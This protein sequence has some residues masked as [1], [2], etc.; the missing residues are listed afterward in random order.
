MSLLKPL[1]FFSLL[2]LNA[3][4]FAGVSHDLPYPDGQPEADEIARQVYFVNHFYAVKN[5]SFERKG[6]NHI[7]VLVKRPQGGRAST[8]SFRR[9]LNNAYKEG[10][11]KARDMVLFHSGSLMGSGILVTDYFDDGKPQSYSV[12]LPETRKLNVFSEPAHDTAWSDSDFTYGDV[13]LRKPEHENHELLGT[14]TLDD[15]L[16]AM[17]LSEREASKTYLNQLPGP[18]CEHKGKAVY[19]L[20]STTKFENWWYDHRISLVDTRTFADYRTDYY[21][22]GKLVKRIDR[23]WTAMPG[24]ADPRAQFWRYWYGTTQDTGHETMVN[25]PEKMVTWNGD[26]ENAFWSEETLKALRK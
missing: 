22:N 12:W 8:D 16:G 15:C 24:V 25:V 10:E 4:A 7:A 5:V 6:K 3:A 19:Q 14:T 21:R 26:M 11:I 20:K 13:Y 23:D 17:K 18:Q 9:F 2:Y 1:G